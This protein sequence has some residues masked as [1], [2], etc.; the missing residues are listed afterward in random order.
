M[1]I[2]LNGTSSSGKTSIAKELQK[3]YYG[4]LLLYG[5]D[6]LVQN[7]FP[8]K[9]DYP[10][11]DEKGMKLIMNNVDNQPHANIIISPYMYPVYKSAVEFYKTLSEQGYNL[12]IDEVLF[13]E[14]RIKPYFDILANETVYF[15][16]VKPE[17]KIAIEWE[18][19]RGDRLIGLAAG[20]YDI[21]YDSRF[22]YDIVI[23]TCK[24][25]PNEAAKIILKYI[26]RN[27]NPEGFN[28]SSNN[29]I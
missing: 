22:V 11:F 7:A 3:E 27:K 19:K 24:I 15:V 16:S 28:L 13:D 1:I 6:M 14:N 26:D 20:L 5:V 21:V 12:I 10:P 4:V 29:W 8:E 18:K 2:L 23:D 17:K 9:C 25:I